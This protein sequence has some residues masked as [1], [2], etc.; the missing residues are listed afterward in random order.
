MAEDA[1]QTMKASFTLTMANGHVV[2]FL[3]NGDVLQT[4]L[5]PQRKMMQRD[6]EDIV[7]PYE[8]SRPNSEVE[9][10]RIVTGKG[11]VIKYMQDGSIVI[12]YANGNI[13]QSQ[14]RNGIWITVNNKGLRKCRNTRDGTETELDAVP[15]ARR[16][17][18]EQGSK[19]IIRSDQTLI[20]HYKDGSAYVKFRDGTQM[21]TSPKKDFII[22]E[23]QGN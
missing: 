20:I 5:N 23:H 19:I 8:E 22:V 6:F 2:K 10:K 9:V 11:S 1:S 12:L 16:T 7:N 14:Q 4:R 3:H 17:D 13:S 15:C 18:P 21:Y